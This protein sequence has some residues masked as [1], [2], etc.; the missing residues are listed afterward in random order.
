[1]HSGGIDEVLQEYV[2]YRIT[3]DA[4]LDAKSR[5]MAR[6]LGIRDVLAAPATGGNSNAAVV[7]EAKIPSVLVESGQL[8]QWDSRAANNLVDRMLCMLQKL[9]VIQQDDE[10]K[11]VDAKSG[12][13]SQPMEWEC[14]SEVLAPVKGLWYREFSLSSSEFSVC[15]FFGFINPVNYL[16]NENF[17]VLVL[18]YIIN[19]FGK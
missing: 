15:V 19:L 11:C 1:M 7:R 17:K 3:G 2:S 5:G 9:G 16:N 6:S 8:G 10:L 18:T 4:V 13:H 14:A 12:D